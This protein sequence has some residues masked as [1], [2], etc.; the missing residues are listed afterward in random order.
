V[1][2]LWFFPLLIS[3]GLVG[4]AV[5]LVWFLTSSKERRPGIAAVAAIPIGFVAVPVIGLALLAVVGG[6]S[7]KSDT[8]LYEEIFGHRPTITE[9]RMLLNDSG[10]GGSR[11]IYM[12]A[13]PSKRERTRLLNISGANDSDFTLSRFAARGASEGFSWW[14]SAEP[15]DR[16][17]CKS[18]RIMDAHGFNG[19]REFRVAECVEAGTEFPASSNVGSVYVIASGRSD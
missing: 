6:A 9:D 13:E 12:R 8:Q 1:W 4:S 18:A 3:L 7:Q 17:Y 10:R 2:G 11:A 19:W 14:V 15:S 16:N 5:G